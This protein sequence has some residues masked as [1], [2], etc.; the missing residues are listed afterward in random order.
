VALI[1]TTRLY[2]GRTHAAMLD[3]YVNGVLLFGLR[4]RARRGR[5]SAVE[6]L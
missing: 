1:C 6:W 2:G 5:T 4:S 3:E